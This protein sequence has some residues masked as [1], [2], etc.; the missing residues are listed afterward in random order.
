MRIFFECVGI[1]VVT[2]GVLGAFNIGHFVLRYSDNKITCTEQ[3]E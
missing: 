2:L 3:A 1:F